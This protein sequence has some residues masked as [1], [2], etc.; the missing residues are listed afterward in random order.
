MELFFPAPEIIGVLELIVPNQQLWT[1]ARIRVLPTEWRQKRLPIFGPSFR[2]AISVAVAKGFAK[3]RFAL[4][5]PARLAGKGLVADLIVHLTRIVEHKGS[6]TLQVEA[7][8]PVGRD[9]E[10]FYVHGMFSEETLTFTHLDGAIIWFAVNDIDRLVNEGRKLKGLKYEKQFR[11]DG[12]VAADVA[13]GVVRSFLPV[14]ELVDEYL[15]DVARL[16]APSNPALEPSA[17]R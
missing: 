14:S 15:V 13:F 4:T 2:K 1:V 3:S 12:H 11:F 17:R 10:V 8:E 7:W 5:D 9:G 6:S 16:D